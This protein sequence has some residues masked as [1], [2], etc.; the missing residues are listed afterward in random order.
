MFSVHGQR[1]SVVKASKTF[2][3]QSIAGVILIFQYDQIAVFS[4]KNV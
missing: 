1:S 4:S 3:H 2:T